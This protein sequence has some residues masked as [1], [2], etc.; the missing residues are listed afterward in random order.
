MELAESIKTAWSAVQDS[1]VPEHMQELA[2]KEALRSLLGTGQPAPQSRQPHKPG[3]GGASGGE[4]KQTPY[5]DGDPPTRVDENDVI[6]AVS[7]HTDVP[8]EKLEKVF[9]LDNDAVKIRVKRSALGGNAAD[10]TRAVAQIITV[11]RKVG[12]RHTDTDFDVIRDECQR[13]HLYDG[14]NFASKHLPNIDGFAVKGEGRNKRL[15]ATNGGLTAFPTL[16]DKVLG[17][18]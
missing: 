2:F 14:G 9:Y 15:K 12:M 8:V 11:V 17:E 10:Q 6:T 7:E 1:G 16:I 18:S 5:D 4:G 13:K 3:G